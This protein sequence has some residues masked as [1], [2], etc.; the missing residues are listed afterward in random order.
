[1][2]LGY[3]GRRARTR[4][5]RLRG[6]ASTYAMTV[7]EQKA[8]R[9]IDVPRRVGPG[10]EAPRFTYRRAVWRAEC[11]RAQDGITRAAG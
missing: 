5:R 1:M 6:A 8:S 11:V 9:G 2:T 7:R 10:E 4:R 3:G